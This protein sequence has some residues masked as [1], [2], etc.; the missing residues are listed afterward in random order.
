LLYFAGVPGGLEAGDA[1]E[2]RA[3]AAPAARTARAPASM[4]RPIWLRGEGC[5]E[6]PVAGL[7]LLALAPAA[8]GAATAPRFKRIA[9]FKSPGTP[10]KLQQG[11]H[12]RRP[13]RRSEER[14]RP[15]PGHL[16]QRRLLRAGRQGHR[17]AAPDWQSG[18]RAAREPA[19]GPLDARQGQGRQRDAKQ[20]FDYYLGWLADSSIQAHFQFIP[21]ATVAYARSGDEH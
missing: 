6:V 18:R 14:P 17:Q 21:D 9:G 16:S 10:A 4:R 3:V 7:M 5:F 20:A 11:R 15:Q 19:R 13:G 8:A 12:P 1:L 2:A